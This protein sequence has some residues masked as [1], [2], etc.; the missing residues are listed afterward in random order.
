MDQEDV[1]RATQKAPDDGETRGN[2]SPPDIHLDFETFSEA[3]I[4]GPKSVGSC[5]YAEHP[6]TEILCL[7]Y[8]FGDEDPIVWTPKDDPPED[9]FDAI[10]SGSL[11]HAWNAEFEIPVWGTVCVER[12]GWPRIPFPSWRDTAALALAHALPGKLETALT[13]LDLPNKDIKGDRLVTK[14]CKPRKPSKNNPDA[15]WTPESAPKDFQDLYLYCA[16][17]VVTERS[18]V[19]C[20]PYD[21]SDVELEIWQETVKMNMR[22]WSV[23]HATILKMI[24]LLALHKV[25]AEREL[26]QITDGY[27]TTGGQV[28][29]IIDWL[30]GH[31]NVELANCQADT[32]VQVL[33]EDLPGPAHRVLQLRQQLSKSS[34]A[35]YKKMDMMIC[36]DGTVKNNIVYHGASTGRDA[37]RGMQIQNFVR[38]AVSKSQEAIEVAVRALELEDPIQAISLLYDEAPTFASLMTRPMLI[39][40]DGMTLYAADLSQI[41]NRT[42]LWMAG[43]KYGIGIYA[44]GLDEYKSF[45]VDYYHTKYDDVTEDQRQHS[46]HAVLGCVFGMGKDA[47]MTQAEV[48]GHPTTEEIAKRTVKFYRNRYPEVPQLWYGL[49]KAAKMAIKSGRST[50]FKKIKFHMD[51]EFDFLF[52]ELPSGRQLAY[53]QP[54]IDMLRVPWGEIKPT[55]THMGLGRN[56][57]WERRKITPGRWTENAVQGAARDVMMHGAKLATAAGYL[58]VGRVHDELITVREEGTGDLQEFCGFLSNPPWLQGIVINADGWTGRRYRK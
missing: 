33:R 2:M 27:V 11:V 26:K 54:Q 3:V 58:Q 7:G 38:K 4:K 39:A 50:Q 41:E 47:F 31:H 36:A 32:I 42:V 16:Q 35:K 23:D 6:S 51:R 5:K 12:M 24:E 56:N 25:V 57:V 30:A 49:D 28:A 55:V 1:A 22:G 29:K 13:A 43:C 45:A 48:F 17:D 44:Q 10:A 53:Y 21:L 15:R 14:L 34:V 37:G 46:K 19:D 20:L 40:G 8:A 52:M 9:L 18:V